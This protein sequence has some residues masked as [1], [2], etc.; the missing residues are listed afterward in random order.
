MH[1]HLNYVLAQFT[2][3]NQTLSSTRILHALIIKSSLC[4]DPF[5][6]TKITRFYSL[7][8][9]LI[10]ARN[11]FDET[12][13]QSIYL[14]NSIIRAY[15]RALKFFDAFLLFKRLLVSEIKPDNYTFACILRACSECFDFQGA[16]VVHG[17]VI[18][19][20]LGLDYICNSSLV[21][22]YSKLSLV[23]EA[24]SVFLAI[25]EPDL[26]HWNAIISCYGSSGDLAKGIELFNEML[27]LGKW[28][29]G[30]TIVGLMTGLADQSLLK[31]VEVVHGFCVK[32]GLIM[33]DHVGSVLV[34]VY[35]RCKNMDLARS[36]FDSLLQPDLVTWSALITGF[37]Q[38]GD[39]VNALT[40]FT[41]LL[42]GGA[43]ADSVLLASVLAASSQLAILGPGCEIHG[44]AVR[45]ERD[46]KV[47]VSSALVD[48]YAKCGFLESG[49]RVFRN[50]VDRNIVSYNSVISGLGLYGRADEAFKVFEELLENGI[51]PDE[52]TF[53]G[54]L[55][56]CCHA[57]LVNK[58]RQYFK[59][60]RDEFGIQAKTEHHVYMVKILGM[61]GQLREAY[62]FIKSL[63]EPVHCSV[64]GALLSCCDAYS[65][66]ELPQVIADHLI[67][68]KWRNR[69]YDVMLSNLYAGKG[70]WNDVKQLRVGSG[71]AKGKTPGIS[72]IGV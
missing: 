22:C 24:S 42:M 38:A 62:E 60:M 26:V 37:S 56:A 32:C 48:M 61:D 13:Q 12:P 2:K 39:Y 71:G 5:Y 20:G 69:S 64:W 35:S 46:T 41:K 28:P 57:G 18:V 72:W 14:W 47:M 70:R 7:N 59:R 50:M 53:S 30:Y 27:K 33:N 21:S 34:C 54:L 15:A 65:T 49:I 19:S 23:A 1:M 55:C 66:T 6:A 8:N 3:P 17:R 51:K 16:R 67:E 68:S 63:H 25:E 9:D 43:R 44:Y 45:H 10:S 31:L 4:H 36:V 29:D 52:A 58:G 40:F 11:L